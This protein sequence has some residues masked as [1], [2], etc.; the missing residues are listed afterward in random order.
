MARGVKGSA[1]KKEVIVVP[2]KPVVVTPT[3]VS[4]NKAPVAQSRP[5]R[6]G[7]R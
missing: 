7:G 1:S 5:G 3:V 4:Q 6:R 2:E